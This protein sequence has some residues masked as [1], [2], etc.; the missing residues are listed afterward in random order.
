MRWSAT[1]PAGRGLRISWLSVVWGGLAGVAEIVVG[2][3]A[4]SVALVGI[5]ATVLVD[6][7]SSVVLVWRFRLQA[8]DPGEHD[9]RALA[10]AERR[11]HL[12][13]STGLLVIGAVLVVS[14]AARVSVGKG[15]HVSAAAIALAAVSVP[16]LTALAHRKYV[17]AR[18]LPSGALKADAH[19]T[20]IGA[21]MA[22]VT[23]LGLWLT[24][25][26]DLHRADPIAAVVVGAL[27]VVE[28]VRSLSHG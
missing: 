22:A 1:T 9:H 13:A 28:G 21:T 6:L 16:V 14:G 27:A 2:A 25:A 11:A 10:A 7:L 4:A 12:M 24:E 23:L 26:L 19:I 8:G 20:A 18:A 5:G 15:A 3:Q 17:I